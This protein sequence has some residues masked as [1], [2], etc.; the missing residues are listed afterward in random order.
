M[1][2]L[3]PVIVYPEVAGAVVLV[4]VLCIA[5]TLPVSSVLAVAHMT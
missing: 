3:H 5:H 1:K 4:D 2:S